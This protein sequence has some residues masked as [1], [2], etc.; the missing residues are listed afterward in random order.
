[1]GFGG[2]LASIAQGLG[3]GMVKVADKAWEQEAE[4]KK[5]KFYA[6]QK[7]LDRTHDFELAEQKHKYDLEKINAEHKS[8]I[9]LVAAQAR[10][11]I[12][13]NEDDINY[14]KDNFDASDIALQEL[15]S[16]EKLLSSTDKKSQEYATLLKKRDI[17]TQDI[18][19]YAKDPRA[20]GI[21][22]KGHLGKTIEADYHRRYGTFLERYK[23]DPIKVEEK[24][25]PN[26]NHPKATVGSYSSGQGFK[27]QNNGYYGNPSYG[28][29]LR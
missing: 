6:D 23:P 11:K 1:M 8:K 13:P 10:Q 22:E 3:G 15:A 25:I 20:K 5:Y 27:T 14:I 12:G 28:A 2:I 16:T 9:G 19:S 7:A 4:D 21:L 24:P 29:G 17:L 18:L 26:V